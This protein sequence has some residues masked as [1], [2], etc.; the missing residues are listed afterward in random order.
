MLQN[1]KPAHILERNSKLV[2][3]QAIT[4]RGHLLA[5]WPVILEDLTV[6][7]EALSR[8]VCQFLTEDYRYSETGHRKWQIITTTQ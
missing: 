3:Q 6:K 4:C 2:H 7:A 1:Y 8:D 5:S